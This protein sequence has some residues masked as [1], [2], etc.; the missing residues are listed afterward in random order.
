[1][2]CQNQIKK[3]I[4]FA[5][6]Q[7]LLIHHTFTRPLETG[8]MTR[9]YASSQKVLKNARPALNDNIIIYK[10]FIFSSGTV[11]WARAANPVDW[12]RFPVGSYR[13][14]E[15]RQLRPVRPRARRWWALPLTRHQ[16]STHC[17]V[18][19]WPVARANRSGRCRSLVPLRKE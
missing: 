19:V 3:K 9:C 17:K 13:R 8:S 15:K 7:Q 14:L 2:K 12:V 18:S 16:C 10:F 1:M 6:W 11:G 5:K 4:R